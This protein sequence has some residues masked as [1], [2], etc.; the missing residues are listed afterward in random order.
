VDE[1]EEG[2]ERFVER[3]DWLVQAVE[4]GQPHL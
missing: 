4:G 1:G 2:G 3:L